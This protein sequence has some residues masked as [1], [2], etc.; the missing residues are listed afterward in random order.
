[1]TRT[2]RLWRSGSVKIA[3]LDLE[4]ALLVGGGDL[5]G[6][7]QRAALGVDV[8]IFGLGDRVGAFD[9]EAGRGLTQNAV[10]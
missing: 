4:A 1:V 5:V 2:N 7:R 6:R 8:Q 9:G 3:L 10:A